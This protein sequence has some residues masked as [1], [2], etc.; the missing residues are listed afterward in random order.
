MHVFEVNSEALLAVNLG[1]ADRS[2]FRR[3]GY[4]TRG[5][6]CVTLLN[7]STLHCVTYCM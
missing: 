4:Y 7:V 1:H 3:S 6:V 2:P 5:E